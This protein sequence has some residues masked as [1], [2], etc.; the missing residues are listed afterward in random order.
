[1]GRLERE[2]LGGK[3][4][5]KGTIHE[6]EAESVMDGDALSVLRRLEAVHSRMDELARSMRWIAVLEQVAVLRYVLDLDHMENTNS[7]PP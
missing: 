4:D 6:G 3:E 1:L 5:S 7:S 2:L